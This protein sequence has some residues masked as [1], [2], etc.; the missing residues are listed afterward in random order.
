[1]LPWRYES[2]PGSVRS[3][4]SACQSKKAISSIETA[5]GGTYLGAAVL[6]GVVSS[7]DAE[8]FGGEF[9]R[10]LVVMG[11]VDVAPARP[12]ERGEVGARGAAGS[13][14]RLLA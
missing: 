6:G 10:A 5:A 1:L 11:A 12:V 2:D 8:T 14:D 3:G 13:G 9:D 7:L 4:Q